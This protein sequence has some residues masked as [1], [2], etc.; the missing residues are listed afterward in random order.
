M[1]TICGQP[2]RDGDTLKVAS[3]DRLARSL[4]DLRNIIDRITAKGATVSF[5]K[6]NLTFTSSH[7]DPRATLLLGILGSFAEFEREIIRERQAEGIALA[8]KKGKYKGR[9]HALTSEQINDIQARVKQGTS[10]S[11]LATEYSVSRSTIYRAL[12]ETP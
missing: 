6:E 3:I 8:R 12:K 4:V 9:Q 10:K 1:S 7:S 5:V 11:V 2:H